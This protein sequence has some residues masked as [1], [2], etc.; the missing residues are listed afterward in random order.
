VRVT[1]PNWGKVVTNPKSARIEGSYFVL[2][3][4]L[5]EVTYDAVGREVFRVT[6]KPSWWRRLLAA[7]R[8]HV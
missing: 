5:H 1:C 8:I 3:Y 6:L 7:V 2:T 4:L